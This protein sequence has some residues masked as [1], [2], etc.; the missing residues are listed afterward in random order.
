MYY[1]PTSFWRTQRREYI[2]DKEGNYCLKLSGEVVYNEVKK[3]KCFD[4]EGNCL[5]FHEKI[6]QDVKEETKIY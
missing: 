3:T 5:G 1:L 4:A 2:K 6:Y